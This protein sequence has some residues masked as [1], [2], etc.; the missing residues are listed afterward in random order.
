MSSYHKVMSLLQNDSQ[1]C[2]PFSSAIALF[3]AAI[4]SHLDNCQ[5]LL[6]SL[7]ASCLACLP[8]C[9]SL[10]SC[11][12]MAALSRILYTASC[13][14]APNYLFSLFSHCVSQ[15][16]GPWTWQSLAYFKAYPRAT[17]PGNAQFTLLDHFS[18]FRSQFQ[19][20]FLGDVFPASPLHS[21]S[22]G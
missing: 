5:A 20:Y 3:Q 18:S 13:S 2:P 1:I 19:W 15:P 21:I 17:S 4:S 8:S 14:L 16:S 22:P 6:V 11:L 10:A 9:H 12:S 7:S